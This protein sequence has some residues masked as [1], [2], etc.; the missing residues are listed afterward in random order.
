MEQSSPIHLQVVYLSC[1]V[2]DN[3][4]D[5]NQ[6]KETVDHMNSRHL[7]NWTI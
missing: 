7:P 4:G 6:G 3:L 5:P 2:T 1:L